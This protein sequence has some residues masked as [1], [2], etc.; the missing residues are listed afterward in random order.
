MKQPNLING[1]SL[2]P[3]RLVLKILRIFFAPF[4][5]FVFR[6]W[7][8]PTFWGSAAGLKYQPSFNFF[9]TREFPSTQAQPGLLLLFRSLT[10]HHE[11]TSLYPNLNIHSS[12][13]IQP[14]VEMLPAWP[15]APPLS[16]AFPSTDHRLSIPETSCAQDV[17]EMLVL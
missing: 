6:V 12:H 17:N 9:Y 4:R 1:I 13:S 5:Y 15:L 10:N 3:L 8:G 11:A 2:K 7:F 14:Q 16:N